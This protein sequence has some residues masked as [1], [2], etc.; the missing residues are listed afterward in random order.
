[1][2]VD[3]SVRAALLAHEPNSAAVVCWYAPTKAGWVSAAWCVT[4][5]ASALGPR[6]RTGRMDPVQA[7][8]ATERFGKLVASGSRRLPVNPLNFHRAPTLTL[9]ASSSLR[10]RAALRLACAMHA[11]AKSMAPLDELPA[12]NALRFKINRL[13]FA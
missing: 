4:E 7:R 9:E 6:Q 5:F 3:T 13:A 1:M 2:N 8:S 11:G 12:R 10:A